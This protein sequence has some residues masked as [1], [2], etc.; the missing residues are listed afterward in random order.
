MVVVN[1]RYETERKRYSMATRDAT[2]K[3]TATQKERDTLAAELGT[4]KEALASSVEIRDST[5]EQLEARQREC[6]TLQA[7][8]DEQTTNVAELAKLQSQLTAATADKNIARDESAAA[9]Q[10]LEGARAE[11]HTTRSEVATLTAQ[12][13]AV[14]AA[15]DASRSELATAQ[16]QLQ[17]ARSERDVNL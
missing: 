17:A 8:L 14:E 9:L 3:L 12:L 4:V 5:I 16:S 7:S 10:E 1:S 11:Y 6:A 13:E 15:L 2:A